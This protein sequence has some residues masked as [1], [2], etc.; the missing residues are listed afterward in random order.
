M[1]TEKDSMLRV[2]LTQRQSDELDAIIDELQAQMPEASVTTSS[3]TRYALEKYVSDHIAKRDGTKLFVEVSTA[4]A[5]DED[6]K[7]LYGLLSKLFDETKDNYS[8]MVHYM[9]GEILEPVMMK[10]ARL[11][12][13]NKPGVKANE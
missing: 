11:M 5:T 4:G 1:S 3:I 13:L 12:K 7:N 6:I 10:M 8:P 9:V 2:R